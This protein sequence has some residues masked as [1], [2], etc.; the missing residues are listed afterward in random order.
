MVGEQLLRERLVAGEYQAARV[1]A[2]VGQPKQLQIADDVLIERG[3]AGKR[4]HQVEHDVRLE[5]S[6]GRADAAELVVESEHP[7]AVAHFPQRL[8][9][10]V[11]HLPFG[12]ED[13]DAGRVLGRHEVIVHE[14]EN[15]KLLHQRNT[16]WP[17]LCR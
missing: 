2:C 6:G 16:R 9:D 12:L 8:D 1:A 17:P 14:R 5:Q 11:L 7:D 10:V 15:P 4:L 13:V 3:Y